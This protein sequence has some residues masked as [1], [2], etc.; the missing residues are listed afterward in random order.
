MRH[1][2]IPVFWNLKAL[3]RYVTDSVRLF[4]GSICKVHGL[5]PHAELQNFLGEEK[6]GTTGN[7]RGSKGI[8]LV[9]TDS[10][11]AFLCHTASKLPP[12]I[13]NKAC[14]RG[15]IS[16][17]EYLGFNSEAGHTLTAVGRTSSALNSVQIRNVTSLARARGVRLARDQLHPLPI[18]AAPQLLVSG[19]DN[20]NGSDALRTALFGKASRSEAWTLSPLLADAASNEHGQRYIQAVHRTQ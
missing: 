2:F 17:S 9:N 16:G 6:N 12:C 18:A 5:Q 14:L 20:G 4:L 13:C 8:S 1:A 11:K 3:L 15:K 19:T 10:I 7:A